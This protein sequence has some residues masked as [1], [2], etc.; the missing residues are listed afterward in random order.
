MHPMK[1]RLRA[2]KGIASYCTANEIVL[3]AA[4]EDAVARNVP[5]LIEAT[6][7][8]VNQFGGY[9]GMQP[10]DFVT[11]IES[12][13]QKIGLNPALVTLG[14]DHLGT[15]P[16]KG[17]PES[18]AMEK[19]KDLIRAY[20]MAG[21]TK[22]HLD[23]SMRLADDATDVPLSTETIAKRGASL[24]QVAMEAW[25]ARRKLHPDARE[26]IFIIGSEVPVPG[27][28]EEDEDGISVTSAEDF[29]DTVSVYQ[30]V[31]LEAGLETAWQNVV[32]I[33]VQPGVEFSDNLVFQYD[34][35]AAQ[36]LTQKLSDYPNLVFEGHSTDYQTEDCLS[37]MVG[38]GIRILKVGPELTFAFRE[39]L[40]ALCCIEEELLPE[41]KRANFRAVLD[42]EMC[43]AP[44]Y[45]KPYY[46]G[47]EEE[48]ACARMFSLSDRCRYYLGNAAVQAA[49]EKLFSNIDAVQIPLGV[50][51][52]YLPTAVDAALKG[53]TLTAR[54]LTK[55]YMRNGVFKKYQEALGA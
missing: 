24:A 51:H 45:W 52:Q 5:I 4:M 18:L 55:C 22:I 36:K 53:E 1:E 26:L 19:A 9:T 6:A 17:E 25:E 39:A 34:S 41:A 10:H 48:Q 40:L 3:E 11:F 32:G 37:A 33:V 28:A 20:V 29:A 46:R 44:Q 7:N 30:T 8:Q 12:L 15:L 16:W 50:L 38:D 35:Q 23:T 27:G 54:E 31:F 43:A 42:A 2:K 14:G 13:V 49:M 47:T 21:F